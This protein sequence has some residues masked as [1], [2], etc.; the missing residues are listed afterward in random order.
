MEEKTKDKGGAAARGMS[1]KS[2][3][4]A[5]WRALRE[6]LAKWLNVYCWPDDVR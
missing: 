3:W 4:R 5:F 6:R 2:R 1:R